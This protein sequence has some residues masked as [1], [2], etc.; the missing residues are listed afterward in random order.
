MERQVE[1]K[2]GIPNHIARSVERLIRD[3]DQ[4]SATSNEAVAADSTPSPSC[5]RSEKLT[6]AVGDT[7]FTAKEQKQSE[8]DG[9]CDHRG[10]STFVHVLPPSSTIEQ[11]QQRAGVESWPGETAGGENA[12]E[13]GPLLEQA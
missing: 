9:S 13:N 5:L 11:Q 4:R 10:V 3:A 7:D 1:A 2:Y 6:G 8:A 12:W